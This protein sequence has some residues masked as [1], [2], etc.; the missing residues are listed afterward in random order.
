[1]ASVGRQPHDNV[2]RPNDDRTGD[3]RISGLTP[4]AR[5]VVIPAGGEVRVDW[6]VKAVAEGRRGR[7]DAGAD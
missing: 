7:H 3:E 6:R 4:T 5:R 1:M 2:E